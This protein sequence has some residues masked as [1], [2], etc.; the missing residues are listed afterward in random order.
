MTAAI[1]PTPMSIR[2]HVVELLQQ[3]L[4]DGEIDL[5]ADF[6]EGLGLEWISKIDLIES[7]EAAY[8]IEVADED[9]CGAGTGAAVVDLVIRTLGLDPDYEEET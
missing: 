7:L 4:G 8:Q 9:L 6:A 1:P 5:D 3:Q 2:A